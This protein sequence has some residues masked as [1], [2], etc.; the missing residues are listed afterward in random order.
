MKSC[1]VKSLKAIHDQIAAVNLLDSMLRAA[2]FV[3]LI[4]EFG[5]AFLS[6]EA[7]SELLL[8]L[9]VEKLT[10]K[11]VEGLPDA[12]KA[13][14]SFQPVLLETLRKIAAAEW[15]QNH[16]SGPEYQFWQKMYLLYG[17]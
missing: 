5:A 8:N 9:Q 2:P 16:L 4:P 15:M 7:L 17:G 13:V 1:C 14:A 11:L 6:E 3:I 10:E 12:Q